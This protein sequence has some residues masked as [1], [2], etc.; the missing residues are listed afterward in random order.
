VTVKVNDP[1]RRRPVESVNNDRTTLVSRCE[2]VRSRE[3]RVRVRARK[4]DG[5]GVVRVRHEDFFESEDGDE[6]GLTG[7]N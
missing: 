4:G 2:G 1:G 3:R 7:L 6:K 5:A